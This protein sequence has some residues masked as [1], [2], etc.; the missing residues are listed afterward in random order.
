LIFQLG[1][2]VALVVG[3][4]IVYQVLS[5]D[6]ANHLPEYATLKA[7]GYG[8]G[9]LA[10][11]VLQQAAMLAVLGFLPGLAISAVLYWL[12]RAM[13][14]VPIEMTVGRVFFVFGLSVLMCTISGL[15]AL[16]KVRSA[17]PADLF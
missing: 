4:A 3:T 16:R 6:V 5:S 14:R 8:G 9:Y 2:V 10:G 12:T 1:V 17:D 7:I 11:V 13:A 15:G